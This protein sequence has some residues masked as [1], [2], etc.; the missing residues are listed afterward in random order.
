M[1]KIFWI[2][3]VK[4]EDVLHSVT[5]EKNILRTIK[6]GRLTVLVTHCIG[7]AC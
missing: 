3:G 5:E 2:D 4:N 6:K 1:E 7:T